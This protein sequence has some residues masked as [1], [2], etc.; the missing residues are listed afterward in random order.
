MK[1]IDLNK[2]YLLYKNEIDEAI[3]S[4]LDHG[5]YIMGPEIAELEQKLENYVGSKCLTVSSG[6]HSLEIILRAL[7]IGPGDDVITVPFTWISSSEVINLVGARPVFVD[8]KL[9]DF[10][11][12]EKAITDA[13]TPN[14]K[15]IIVVNLFGQCPNYNKIRESIPNKITIIEDAAQSF[16]ATQNKIKSCAL[17]DI[18]ST[19]FFPAKPFGCYGDGGAIFSNNQ[20]LM[21]RCSA[22]RSHGGVV[23]H[24]HQYVGTNGR[25]DTIQAAILL[26]KFKHFA[27]EVELRMEV[28]E[29][30]NKKLKDYYEIPETINGNTHVYAQYCLISENRDSIMSHLKDYDIPTAIY[31]P[32]CL[33]EQPVY[34]YLGHTLGDFQNSE[35]ASKNIFSIPMHPYLTRS[36]QDKIITKLIDFKKG[37]I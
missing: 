10:N 3:T 23:R 7:E 5:K 33:H 13:I 4:V 17:G 29:Y 28:G 19:S 9:N 16:G 1:F 18:S 32:K 8:I 26:A 31:Y 11:I 27:E 35:Y 2:Q 6:T 21:K 30:Y 15:A 14:T 22:I 37:G 12:D 20:E 36:E 25:L 34:E 24:H